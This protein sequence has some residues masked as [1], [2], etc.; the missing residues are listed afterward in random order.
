MKLSMGCDVSQVQ[1]PGGTAASPLLRDAA[2]PRG[3][4]WLV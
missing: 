1:V 2:V 4:T 3:F